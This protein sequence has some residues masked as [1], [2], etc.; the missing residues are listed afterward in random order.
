VITENFSANKMVKGALEA[1]PVARESDIRHQ[2]AMLFGDCQFQYGGRRWAR[3][4]AKAGQPSFRYVF[5]RERPG[6]GRP[7]Q[8]AE[9]V[10][11]VFGE[12]QLPSDGKYDATDAKV[13]ETMMD[14]WIRF[15]A[16]GDPNGPGL[17]TW[18]A[19]DPT[20]DSYMEFADT[21][22]VGAGFRRAQLD[23]LDRYFGA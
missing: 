8:H 12:P 6:L 23:F 1:Y 13:S 22:R 14:A 9:E 16:T 10:E 4:M 7:P 21:P 18:P 11:Y 15:A 5:T 19:Y 3:E 17:P 20:A 2:L